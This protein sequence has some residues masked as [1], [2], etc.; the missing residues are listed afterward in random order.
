MVGAQQQLEA[1]RLR[2][3][4]RSA[5]AA[6]LVVVL[7]AQRPVRG[8]QGLLARQLSRGIDAV[9]RAATDGTGELVRV[10]QQVVAP[11]APRV[12]DRS[13]QVDEARQAMARLLRKVR[14]AV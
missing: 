8:G 6:P 4:R 7:L 11:V 10:A 13:A 12:V 14:P 3:L 1:H 5:E 9:E 2:E